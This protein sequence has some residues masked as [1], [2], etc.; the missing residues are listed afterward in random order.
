MIKK[1]K[2]HR[3]KANYIT[4]CNSNLFG[5]HADAIVT[6][7]FSRY[8]DDGPTDAALVFGEIEVFWSMDL[9]MYTLWRNNVTE[10]SFSEK[11]KCLLKTRFL[12]SLSQN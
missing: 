11:F 1:K 9:K 3:H 10:K 12:S 5:P 8:V 6:I 7:K 4:S 2:L